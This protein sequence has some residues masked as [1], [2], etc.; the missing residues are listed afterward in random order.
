MKQILVALL[1]NALTYTPAHGTVTLP[2][3]DA[4]R[5]A[6]LT[7]RD[8]GRGIAPADLPHIFERF[9]RAD[10]AQGGSGPGLA[11]AQSI[12]HALHGQTAVQSC[13][14]RGLHLSG[15]PALSPQWV[16]NGQS[17][18]HQRARSVR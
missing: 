7:I 4:D 3:D 11:I 1:D 18:P 8:T 14:C 12:V 10:R 6:T 17:F 16:T 15:E 2:L 9:C 13:P 5:Q